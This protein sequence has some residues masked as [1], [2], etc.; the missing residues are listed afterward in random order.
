MKTLKKQVVLITTLIFISHG[1]SFGQGI[2]YT[3]SYTP[4]G[5]IVWGGINNK[6]ISGLSFTNIQQHNIL[7][8][9]CSNIT[10]QNCKFSKSAFRAIS[11][12]NSKNLI[13]Q[14]CVFDSVADGI[15]I[16]C[17]ESNSFNNGTSSGVQIIHNYF[18][19]MIGGWPGAH[20]ILLDRTNGGGIKV[21]YN[22][23]EGILNQSK[24][25]DV[26]NINRCYGSITDS[27]QVFGNWFRGA[28]Y[29][30]P[31]HNG[32]GI[33]FG[34]GGG[35]YIHI[36]NNIMVNQVGIGNAGATNSTV[37]NNTVY[38]S[39]ALAAD[40]ACGYVQ[41]N[42]SING[43]STTCHDNIWQNNRG[44][45]LNSN[46][47]EQSYVAL[48]YIPGN[49]TPAIG[50]STNIVDRTLNATILPTKISGK[51]QEVTTEIVSASATSDIKIY[52]N[53]ASD[54]ITIE[55][56]QDLTNGLIAIYNIK[57]QKIIEKSIKRGNMDLDTHNLPIGIY[58]M[59][60]SSNNK[61][62]E[63]KKLIIGS[64]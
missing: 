52:P 58:I 17:Q 44:Y 43:D 16:N 6:V 45:C 42:F 47:E 33:T 35:S 57:G 1:I 5:A 24:V 54:H 50:K 61:Q 55:T 29:S 19:N 63:E 53:P 37:E 28:D 8:Y 15:L 40:A 3:G 64:N 56:A 20:A 21:N 4:S 38:Q 41:F 46:G 25:D 2:R 11:A 32:G 59:K 62:I 31:G 51:V 12:E 9:E 14:D 13:I 39:K 10:I 7:L 36:K 23:F 34:D 48:Q 22:S 18:K 49:C 60:I 26:I 27:I 30:Q